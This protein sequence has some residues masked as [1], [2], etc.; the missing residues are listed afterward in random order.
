MPSAPTG[1]K[2]VAESYGSREEKQKQKLGAELIN[3]DCSAACSLD[4]ETPFTDELDVFN[5]LLPLHVFALEEHE[6]PERKQTN[7]IPEEEDTGYGGSQL[8]V[9]REKCALKCRDFEKRL[10]EKLVTCEKYAKRQRVVNELRAE[11]KFQI[12]QLLAPE[13][14]KLLAEREVNKEKLKAEMGSTTT[15]GEGETAGGAFATA[16]VKDEY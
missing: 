3:R 8:Q 15:H 9:W 1:G 13:Y 14:K 6:D 4:I 2:K 7:Q 16:S 5:R 12:D 10:L 11:E